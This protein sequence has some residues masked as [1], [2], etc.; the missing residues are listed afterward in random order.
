MITAPPI[1]WIARAAISVSTFGASAPAA[2]AAV[3]TRTPAVNTRRR[4]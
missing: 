1:P 4:P 2:D 3:N